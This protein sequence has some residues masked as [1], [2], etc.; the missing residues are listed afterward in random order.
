MSSLCILGEVSG[1]LQPV[2]PLCH[3]SPWGK[4]KSPDFLS[5]LQISLDLHAI[6]LQNTKTICFYSSNG[7][8]QALIGTYLLQMTIEDGFDNYRKQ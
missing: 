1:F 7:F 8:S 2:S 4:T 5:C 6:S 3:L